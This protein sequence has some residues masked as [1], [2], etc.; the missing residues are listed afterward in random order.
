MIQALLSAPSSMC[1]R[2]HKAQIFAIGN[3]LEACVEGK[4]SVRKKFDAKGKME[5][6]LDH[7]GVIS[8]A[9]KINSGENYNLGRFSRF[10]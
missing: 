8:L 6:A 1:G 3:A 7:R 4:A 10:R 9:V 5:R 2:P